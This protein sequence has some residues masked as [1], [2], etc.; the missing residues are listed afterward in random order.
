M[1]P[2]L[3]FHLGSILALIYSIPLT[4]AQST[5]TPTV[6]PYPGN[7]QYQLLGCYNE[8]PPEAS[9]RALG[10]SGTYFTPAIASPDDLT[11][12]LCLEGCSAALTPTESDGYN[13]A[14]VENS[15]YVTSTSD[16]L[17]CPALAK[18]CSLP[19]RMLLWPNTLEPLD[20]T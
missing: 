8:L 11:V 15:R 9:A 16:T 5:P 12:Q 3:P 17:T 6:F 13:Y 18:T 4:T 1:A 19:K 14:C 20:V 10:A 7:S 2:S